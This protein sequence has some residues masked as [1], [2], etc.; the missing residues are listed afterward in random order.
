M[1][2]SVCT[3]LHAA[4]QQSCHAVL[5]G[6]EVRVGSL[7]IAALEVWQPVSDSLQPQAQHALTDEEC[8]QKHTAEGELA[9]PKHSGTGTVWCTASIVSPL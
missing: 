2:G 6:H 1:L 7:D 9:R 5:L 8:W 3:D 4:L